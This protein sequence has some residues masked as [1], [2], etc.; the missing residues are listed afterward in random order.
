MEDSDVILKPLSSD[1][2]FPSFPDDKLKFSE[3]SITAL[4]NGH[5]AG[6][7][8][9]FHPPNFS[10]DFMYL[11]QI[12]IFSSMD[13]LECLK[14][15]EDFVVIYDLSLFRLQK[16]LCNLLTEVSVIDH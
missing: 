11:Q 13:F 5:F 9:Y 7:W 12:M 3:Q 16:L 6:H 1:F 15:M 14:G 10:N 4:Y 8:I 2:T